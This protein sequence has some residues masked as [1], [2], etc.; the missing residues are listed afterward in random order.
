M[1]CVNMSPVSSVEEEQAEL[2]FEVGRK[3]LVPPLAP[4]LGV[5]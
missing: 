3:S 2:A 4:S 5:G 1:S